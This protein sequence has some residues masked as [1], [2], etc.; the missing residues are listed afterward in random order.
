[1][2][3]GEILRDLPD[4]TREDISACLAFAADREHA[5]VIVTKDFDFHQRSFFFGAPPKATCIRRGN[6]STAEIESILRNRHADVAAFQE[7]ADAAL[8][9]RS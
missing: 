6:C 9:A 4:L 2:T 7:D 5:Y 1:M 8:L 3:E